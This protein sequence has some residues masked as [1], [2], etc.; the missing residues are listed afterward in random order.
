MDATNEVQQVNKW[1]SKQILACLHHNK[2]IN[3]NININN[4]A[5][6]NATLYYVS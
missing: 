4:T 3:S 5:F 2:N 6:T 1:T